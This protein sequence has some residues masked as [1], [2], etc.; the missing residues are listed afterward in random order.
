ML[1][2]DKR[3]RKKT[4]SAKMWY[5]RRAMRLALTEKKAN[6]EEMERA[7]YKRSLLKTIR[8]RQL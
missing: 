1:A 4:W 6:E 2:T 8:K 3:P 5:M 7:G